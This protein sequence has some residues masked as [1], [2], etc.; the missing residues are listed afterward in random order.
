VESWVVPR[1]CTICSHPQRLEIERAIVA[2]KA[3][4]DIAGQFGPSKTAIAR[5]RSHVTDSILKHAVADEQTRAT[6]LLEDVRAGE[7][8]ARNL[9]E[10]AERITTE[11]LNDQDRRTALQ[12]IKT[13]ISALG[14]SRAYAILRGE[15][16]N[17]LG[18][19]RAQPEFAIQIVC[20]EPA[21]GYDDYKIRL[22]PKCDI[23]TPA[24]DESE[25]I[26]EIALLRPPF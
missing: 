15:L 7:R 21:G 12:G 20:P 6:T 9:L 19:D 23:S 8:R 3:I 14:E 25:G 24:E 22:T 18:R 2:G 16:T 4:R 10:Q 17:E 26:S 13:A 1:T 5:H 11:A